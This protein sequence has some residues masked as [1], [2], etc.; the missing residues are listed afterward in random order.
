MEWSYNLLS[1]AERLFLNRLAVFVGGWTLEAAECVCTDE[2]IRQ[3]EAFNLLAQ[4]VEKSLVVVDR[5]P[6]GLRYRFLETIHQ[7][8]LEKLSLS[9]SIATLKDK[10]LDYFLRLIERVELEKYGRD[11]LD[12]LNQIEADHDNLRA[13]LEWSLNSSVDRGIS[14][15]LLKQLGLFWEL[16]GFLDE[17]RQRLTAVLTRSEESA[18]T[19][20]RAEL[21][22]QSAW[23][24][25]YQSDILAGKPLLEE[26]RAIFRQFHPAGLRG[27]ADVL[28]SLAAIEIDSGEA[29][30]ALEYAQKALEIATEIGDPIGVNWA[31]HMMGVALG[32]LGEFDPAWKHLEAALVS[33]SR[34]RGMPSY[35]SLVQSHG[36]LAA[37]Q[38][39]YEKADA[40]LEQSLRLAREAKDKWMI[41]AILGTQGWIALRLREF[42]QVRKLLGESIAVRQEIGD[43]GG[44]AWCLEKL[45]GS[46]ALQGK[47]EIAVRILGQAASLRLTVNSPVNSADKPDYDRLLRSLHERIEPEAF[48]SA[49]EAGSAMPL[50]EAID[51]ALEA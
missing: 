48:Q 45:A 22:F 3:I 2:A 24:A 5:R 15:R 51:L 4:L 32:H 34:K 46:A 27:E 36:E 19:L 50:N 25:I 10:H 18:L 44:I 41:G 29:E 1:D 16:R 21:L 20:E 33:F 38:G 17:G 30:I 43:K 23:L 35:I 9:E 13:A 12:A 11:L 47:P 40:Y 42:V 28:N 39:D 31:H 7:Y 26:S 8:A 49:W 14:F 6:T 37:W